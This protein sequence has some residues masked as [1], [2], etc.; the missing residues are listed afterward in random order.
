MANG[1][2]GG[3]RGRRRTSRQTIAFGVFGVALAS[4]A[5][6]LVV[7]ACSDKRPATLDEETSKV[8][9]IPSPDGPCAPEGTTRDCHVVIGQHEGVL[10][11][12]TGS[13]TC[14]N[15]AWTACGSTGQTTVQSVA[16]P[17]G[18][19]GSDMNV[20]STAPSGV[21]QLSTASLSS[22]SGPGWDSGYD[23]G[24]A[25]ACASNPCDPACVGWAE[26]V[27]GGITG[28]ASTTSAWVQ[29]DFGGTIPAGFFQK[30]MI[31]CDQKGT[32]CNLYQVPPYAD[33][34]DKWAACQ[35]DTYCNPGVCSAADAASGSCLQYAA[36]QVV[37]GDAGGC[38]GIDL[39][40]GIPCLD[41]AGDGHITFTI[42]NRGTVA[43]PAT[44]T[45]GLDVFGGASSSFP[46]APPCTKNNAPNCFVTVPS[47]APGQCHSVRYSEVV[48]N[49][50][51]NSNNCG[52]NLLPAGV[53][54]NVTVLVN[55]NQA[56]TEC[57]LNVSPYND[58]GVAY[59]GCEDNWTDLHKS[60]GTCQSFGKQYGTAVYQQRY[61]ATCGYGTKPQWGLLS[62]NVTTP[63]SGGVS[64]TV[65]FQVST[66]ALLSD[67]GVPLDAGTD[68]GTWASVATAPSP[69][70]TNCPMSGVSG[71]P[72]DLYTALGGRP[73]S[74]YEVLD[75]RVTLTPSTDL[76]VAPTLN[77]WNVTYS[78]PPSQ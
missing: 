16:L 68:A 40:A 33:G 4:S 65:K 29:V 41:T 9:P 6:M 35:F 11:C 34:G 71:C 12:F 69:D 67:G 52:S 72:K 39:T 78:C 17:G 27:D 51:G 66:A 48:P 45:L 42:C 57:G 77:S 1:D 25:G 3:S 46:T 8:P 28:D 54:G 75:L 56:I 13:Q 63:S 70:P 47:I 31:D 58:A 37:P 74:N 49:G 73:L 76:Q 7:A 38:S 30:G 10:S 5:A 26:K 15:G 24:D 64:S 62:Y 22:P 2:G 60:G 36:N 19:L 44:T 21:R 50:N 18:A 55:S 61:I 14:T 43:S 20:T 23:A 32:P 53:T 59:K